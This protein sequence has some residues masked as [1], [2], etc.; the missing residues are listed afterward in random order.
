VVVDAVDEYAAAF[1]RHFGFLELTEYRL[2][3]RIS[4]IERALSA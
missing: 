2:W 4:D 1:Y 3:R